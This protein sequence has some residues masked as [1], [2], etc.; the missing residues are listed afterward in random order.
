VNPFPSGQQPSG[1]LKETNRLSDEPLMRGR[2]RFPSWSLEKDHPNVAAQL[3]NLDVVTGHQPSGGSR[4]AA[5]C[6]ADFRG[7]GNDHP[8]VATQPSNLAELLKDTTARRK[9]FHSC[10]GFG[11]SRKHLVGTTCVATLLN[12]LAQLLRAKNQL[13][14]EPLIRGRWK[15]TG[16]AMAFHPDVARDLNNLVRCCQTNR[17]AAELIM[18]QV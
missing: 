2:W 12:N 5:A 6:P 7:D 17:L 11:I 18:R 14:A 3:D 4:A 10:V 9:R 16:G 8:S 13:P 15:S 1:L